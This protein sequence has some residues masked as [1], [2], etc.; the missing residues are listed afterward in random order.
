MSVEVRMGDND[1]KPPSGDE[2]NETPPDSDGASEFLD[3]ESALPG[4]DDDKTPED[5]RQAWEAAESRV[6]RRGPEALDRLNQ[7]LLENAAR[8]T[9]RV[10]NP[11]LREHDDDVEGV[12]RYE[13]LDEAQFLWLRER[14]QTLERLL[15]L[16]VEV[17]RAV[18]DHEYMRWQGDSDTWGYQGET[19]PPTTGSHGG[20]GEPLRIY[21]SPLILEISLLFFEFRSAEDYESWVR[22]PPAWAARADT[23]N[24]AEYLTAILGLPDIRNFGDD[25]LP[26]IRNLGDLGLPSPAFEV[27]GEWGFE[28]Q[29]EDS[30]R[31]VGADEAEVGEE[32]DERNGGSDSEAGDDGPDGSPPAHR[33]DDHPDL[34]A[35]PVYDDPSTWDVI[36]R[37]PNL[38]LPLDVTGDEAQPLEPLDEV[39]DEA[40]RARQG[41]EAKTWVIPTA[42]TAAVAAAITALVLFFS[43]G[44]STQ[45]EADANP[46]I[47]EPDPVEQSSDGPVVEPGDLPAPPPEGS[48]SG[49]DD[50]SLL[51]QVGPLGLVTVDLTFTSVVG[52]PT[53][54]SG[55]D[56]RLFQ[57]ATGPS[58]DAAALEDLATVDA[59]LVDQGLQPSD[60]AI[61]VTQF[62]AGNAQN[63]VGRPVETGDGFNAYLLNSDPAYVDFWVYEGTLD[64]ATQQDLQIVGA[65]AGSNNVAADPNAVLGELHGMFA[66][67]TF[68]SFEV[69]S[70][71][72]GWFYQIS[73]TGTLPGAIE[74][75]DSIIASVEA[76]LVDGNI[77]GIVT[78][79]EEM[80]PPGVFSRSAFFSA[81]WPD[82]S[83]ALFFYD[84]NESGCTAAASCVV[85]NACTGLD[86]DKFSVTENDFQLIF[87][88]SV[89]NGIP[90]LVGTFDVLTSIS[91]EDPGTTDSYRGFTYGG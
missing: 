55:I 39:D 12:S 18:Y 89:L 51:D 13:P 40:Q 66:A 7:M 85:G 31:A 21:G 44:D 5:V 75:T 69:E 15:D 86:F 48:A 16:D 64:G 6:D 56:M 87:D 67:G 68:D 88:L 70:L 20:G 30:D 43:G 26:D 59:F 23:D 60:W 45:P 24:S 54:M 71:G 36:A 25:P 82:E 29:V 62:V 76:R 53:F 80:L 52:D 10:L 81:Q 74:E 90:D 58:W 46:V 73:G 50:V 14:A 49:T 41:R 4:L 34:L 65:N 47:V 1:P 3:E 35:S 42:I 28:E 78:L 32:P 91:I 2:E 84:C 83:V 22:H 63:A 77:Q 17:L 72:G 79:T 57:E 33:D 37:D 9:G 19:L 61:I 27:P 11:E 8:R 38:S